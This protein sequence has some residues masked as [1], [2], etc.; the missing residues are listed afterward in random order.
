VSRWTC[1]A[2]DREFGRV[3]QA[4]VCVPGCS[5]EE[6]FAGRP[7]VQRE[8]YAELVA[9]LATLGPVH[10]D[11]V[12][13]GVFVKRQRKLAEIRP[14]AR[15]LSLELVLPRVVDDPRVVRTIRLPGDRTVHVVRLTGRRDV[16]EQVRDWLAEAYTAAASD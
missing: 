11:V 7:P 14:M 9:E 4:H 2:C 10:L 6:C 16:D 3:H 15:S 5:L 8:I 13:V 1:P 12:R